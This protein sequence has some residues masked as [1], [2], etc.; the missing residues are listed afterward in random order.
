MISSDCLNCGV[1]EFMCPEGAIVQ[2]PNQFIITK[3]LCTGC[4]KCVPY[5]LVRAI[6][7]RERFAERQGRTVKEKLRRVLDA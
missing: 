6:T 7:P 1:C 4:A 5:C 3:R 2:A